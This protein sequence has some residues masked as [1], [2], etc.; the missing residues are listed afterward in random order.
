MTDAVLQLKLGSKHQ[1]TLDMRRSMLCCEA[2]RRQ[3][4]VGLANARV[5]ESRVLN[6]RGDQSGEVVMTAIL[7]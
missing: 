7:S 1:R 4:M 3:V 2:M 6:N 5:V